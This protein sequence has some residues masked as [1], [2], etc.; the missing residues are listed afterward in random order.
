MYDQEE[1]KCDDDGVVLLKGANGVY[2]T[3]TKG[4]LD[5]Y[6]FRVASGNTNNY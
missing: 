6:P 4:K 2:S 1:E 5:K 3:F